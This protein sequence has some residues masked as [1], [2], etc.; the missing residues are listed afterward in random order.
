[1]R[2]VRSSYFLIVFILFF[3]KFLSAQ[4]KIE[5][6]YPKKGDLII[7]SDSTFIFGNVWP[8]SSQIFVNEKPAVMY[9]NGSFLAVVPVEPGEF[10]FTCLAVFEGEKKSKS[11]Q[12]HIPHYLKTSTS[13][14]IVFDSSYVFPRKDW[15]LRRG[16]IFKVAV[17]GTPGL[18]AT[19]SIEGLAKNLPMRELPS[20]RRRNWGE[21]KFR[22]GTNYQMSK[23]QGIYTGSYLIDSLDIG[24]EKQIFFK[25]ENDSGKVVQTTAKGT[26]SID[27]LNT[28][29]TVQLTKEVIKLQRGW[30]IGGQ[31][32]LPQGAQFKLT[33]TRGDHVRIQFLEN[34]QFWIKKENIKIIH[35]D[36]T[37]DSAIVSTIR[38]HFQ[39][40]WAGVEI[41]LNQKLP[42]KV[43][44][45]NK[46]TRVAVT[47][48]GKVNKD[49]VQ[50]ALTDPLINDIQW[51]QKEP[52]TSILKIELNQ[53][54][55][56][57]YD[58]Y[59][60]NG[61]FFINIKKKPKISQWPYSPLKNIVICLDPGHNPDL[62]AVSASGIFEKDVNFEYCSDLKK[63]LEKKGAFVVLTHN[64]ANGINI[65]DRGKLAKFLE[66]DILLSIHFN[67]LPDGVNPYKI[68]GISSYYYH[69]HSYQLASLIQENMIEKTE[70]PS[71]GFYYSSL[72]ICRI[73][74][75]ISVLVEPGFIT[76][77]EEEILITSELY[78]NKI[79]N[80]I[81]KALE[82]FLKERR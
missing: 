73:P 71:F 50:I 17:K 25:L 42:F 64:N 18:K 82:E 46:P 72:A 78:K 34:K 37:A 39:D 49:S 55:H 10:I 79:L 23:V 65:Q 13:D 31:L 19:F 48:Y 32:Y 51:E 77:P 8:K 53:D 7:A 75:M 36:T 24:S 70:M 22:Q 2:G 27:T 14:S 21:A 81:V 57:G 69:P 30:R 68:R 56:W 15:Q 4:P 26:L 16:D 44:E 38:T 47:F 45:L 52:G 59:Y 12:V 62:G 20:K 60:E 63:R 80:G 9:P 76:I 43:E 54:E 11:R 74:Q 66:A 28:P 5:I 35:P 6:I 61:N 33:G 58:P 40:K 41:F 3:G 29:E 1:M 67:A